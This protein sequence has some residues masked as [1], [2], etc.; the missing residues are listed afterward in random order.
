MLD[1]ANLVCKN[2]CQGQNDYKTGGMF[3]GLF[4]APKIK[5]CL[6]INELGVIEQYMTFKGFNDSKRL[7]DRYQYF[8]MLKGKKITALL[9][10]SWKKSFE[11]GVIIP[12]KMR[13]CNNAMYV[14]MEY[15]VQLV[16]IKSMKIKNS[17]LI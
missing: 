9:P 14:K 10:R 11:I 12:T 7:L 4:L 6:T 8:N 17:K 3:Y 15:Y 13:Q 16:I 5:Y 2:L 1:K